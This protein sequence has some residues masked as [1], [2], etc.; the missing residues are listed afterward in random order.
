MYFLGGKDIHTDTH[1]GRL[2]KYASMCLFLCRGDL[3]FANIT[4]SRP[5]SI[6]RRRIRGKIVHG[7]GDHKR[8]MVAQQDLST[9]M[10]QLTGVLIPLPGTALQTLAF[11][12]ILIA[13][14]LWCTYKRRLDLMG[15][16]PPQHLVEHRRLGRLA[17][18]LCH[19]DKIG[20]TAFWAF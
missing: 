14:Y 4:A 10:R 16:E 11:Y 13:L 20:V 18:L 2:A 6:Y 8:N 7:C 9:R 17:E 3:C 19:E 5:T 1:H 12:P 15:K